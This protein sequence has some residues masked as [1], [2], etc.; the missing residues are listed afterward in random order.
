MN[1]ISK[2]LSAIQECVALAIYMSELTQNEVIKKSGVGKHTV[3]RAK[4]GRAE[5]TIPNVY[6][7]VDAAGF[8]FDDL[9][10]RV[11]EIRK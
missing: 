3:L 6:A 1:K 5:I 4:N 2:K 11:L 9:M 7:I 10:R 8:E